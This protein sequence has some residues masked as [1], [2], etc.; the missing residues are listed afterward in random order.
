[1]AKSAAPSL[2]A[3][4]QGRDLAAWL[5]VADSEDAHERAMAAWAFAELGHKSTEIDEPLARLLGDETAAV[6][7][8][9]L[10]AIDRLA[11]V[12][13][14][15]WPHLLAASTDE[16]VGRMAAHLVR[17]HSPVP[18]EVLVEA[19]ETDTPAPGLLD[20]YAA[21]PERGGHQLPFERVETFA[22][23]D[24]RVTWTVAYALLAERG[25]KGLVWLLRVLHEGPEARRY[26]AVSELARVKALELLRASLTYENE[27]VRYWA[28]RGI[29][30]MGEAGVSATDALL[31]LVGQ[32]AVAPRQGAI[33]ALV[34][35]GKPAKPAIQEWIANHPDDATGKRLRTLGQMILI[36]IGE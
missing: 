4:F 26:A 19:L 33:E 24:D 15:S 20:R 27:R 36:R 18:F 5:V 28:A 16:T 22:G 8:A 11:R 1:M 21:H 12:P 14:G 31:A 25:E 30:Y 23:S 34:S 17:V 29:G 9:A 6:K 35:I 7:R 10:H 32:D 13:E 2:P 3:L